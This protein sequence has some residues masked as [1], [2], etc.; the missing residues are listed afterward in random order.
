MSATK[1]S[2]SMAPYPTG[3]ACDSVAI[4]FGVVPE[5]ISEWNPEMAPQ[6]MVMKQNGKIF[7]AKMGPVPSVNRV[8]AGS[9]SSGRTNRIP[10]KGNSRAIRM[11]VAGVQVTVLG[12]RRI[13]KQTREAIHEF[14]RYRDLSWPQ[15]SEE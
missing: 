13:A 11:R 5:E 8:N 15:R 14:T 2:S 4:I 7:P 10:S 6:A 9:C 12:R 1:L 3:R